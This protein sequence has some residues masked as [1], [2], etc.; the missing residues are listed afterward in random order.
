MISRL[1]SAVEGFVL[2]VEVAESSREEGKLRGRR[3]R[4]PMDRMGMYGMEP[5]P[6]HPGYGLPPPSMYGSPPGFDYGHPG[7]RGPPT[8]GMN[9]TYVG[10]PYYGGYESHG[11]APQPAPS[12]HGGSS[13]PYYPVHE[14]RAAGYGGDAGYGGHKSFGVGVGGRG[15]VSAGRF[16][17]VSAPPS[18]SEGN[19]PG[20]KDAS[21][22][23]YGRH[24]APVRR[25]SFVVSYSVALKFTARL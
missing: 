5:E 13:N 24:P 2:N 25:G 16:D 21:M 9:P 11:M 10:Y 3:P 15:H 17:S 14:Y 12:A 4:G 18:G 22:F 20:T 8:A 19:T 23:T 7:M 1:V 6:M